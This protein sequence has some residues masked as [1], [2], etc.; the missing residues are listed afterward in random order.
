MNNP[1]DWLVAYQTI[2]QFVGWRKLE[3]PFEHSFCLVH[4]HN[5]GALAILGKGHR[6]L[7][8][9]IASQGP[10]E[11][12]KLSQFVVSMHQHLDWV[13]VSCHDGFEPPWFAV[14]ALAASAALSK[15]ERDE[16]ESRFDWMIEKL[17]ERFKQRLC[18]N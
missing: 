17:T 15:T 2:N 14:G 4:A 5:D 13:Q 6:S 10:L 9:V 16:F 12:E 11:N 8:A 3:T 18:R 1:H 7:Y